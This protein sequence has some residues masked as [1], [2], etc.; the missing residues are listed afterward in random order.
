[1]SGARANLL[2]HTPH[3]THYTLHP[4]PHTPHPTPYTLHTAPYT[5]HP[6]Q[7]LCVGVWARGRICS[8]TQGYLALQ[9]GAGSP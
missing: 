5:L 6:G 4:S 2:V 8:P 3:P 9:K 7:D 1:M